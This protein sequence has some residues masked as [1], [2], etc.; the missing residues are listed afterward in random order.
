MDSP[1]RIKHRIYMSD[2]LRKVL[3]N[4]LCHILI[5][6]TGIDVLRTVN[7][8]YDWKGHKLESETVYLEQQSIDL[9]ITFLEPQN[10]M[11]EFSCCLSGYCNDSDLLYWYI[12][13]LKAHYVF[14]QHVQ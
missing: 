3:P 8:S 11:L 10:V 6:F 1:G 4:R 7:Q 14:H 2:S 5:T 9:Q 12:Q 13:C